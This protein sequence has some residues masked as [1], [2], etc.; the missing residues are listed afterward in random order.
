LRNRDEQHQ[1]RPTAPPG[2]SSRSSIAGFNS[3]DPDDSTV[4]PNLKPMEENEFQIGLTRELMSQVVVGARY[5]YKDLVRTIEDVG[6]LVPG[7]GEVYYIANPGEG[8]TLELADPGRAELPQGQREYQ[9]LEL[10]FEKRFADNWSVFGSYTLSRLYGNYSGLASS[11]EH[12]TVGGAGRVSPNVARY[13]DHIEQTFDR[14]GD[15]VYGRLG[16]DRPHQFKGQGIY[17]FNTNTT[18]ALNQ[19]IASGVPVSEEGRVPISVPF[20]PNGRGNLG[21]TPVLTQTDLSVFQSVRLSQFNLQLGLTV[22]NLWDQDTV[23][24]RWPVRMVSDLPITSTQFFAG[25]WDYEGILAA[26]PNLLNVL[27]N[28]P[29]VYQ[30]PREVRV[31]LKFTF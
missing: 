19:Y 18:L 15:L 12:N 29:D 17:R 28:Q 14:N 27:F 5:I 9:G 22:L 26:R 20:Y 23:T 11:S 4:D 30:A 10:T 1:E 21:R 24:R 16:T 2:L 31:T 13:F 6:I 3:A 25:G 7:I 8:V